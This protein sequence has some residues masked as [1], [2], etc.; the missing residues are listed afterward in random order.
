MSEVRH[1]IFARVYRRLAASAEGQGL[2]D[3]RDE[4][5]RGLSGTVV[6][7][8][9]GDGANFRH[10]PATVSEVVAVEPEPYL[11]ERATE[12]A[13]RSTVP[14]RVIDG[15][16]DS[17]AVPDASADA[18]V[19]CLVLCSVP[20]QET[21]L[22][23][24]WRVLRPG[25][26][27]RFLEHVLDHAPGRLQRLQRGVDRCGWPRLFGGCHTARD[28][29]GALAAAGFSV[30]DV[31]RSYFPDGIHTPVSPHVLG[32]ARRP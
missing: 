32:R 10:Y 22:A 15:L 25:G 7:V 26:E 27:V 5:L 8:G 17:L 2:G 6:E 9:P 18:V 21:A 29:V 28:T 16:A 14:V 30:E 1:P 19:L 24:A 3:L 4:L 20:A 12:A 13:G 31:D 11:R 23:E